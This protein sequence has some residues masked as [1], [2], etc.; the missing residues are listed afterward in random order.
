MGTE[1]QPVV[2]CVGDPFGVGANCLFPPSHF[3][4][5]ALPY[6]DHL[7]PMIVAVPCCDTH[8]ALVCDFVTSSSSMEA[9]LCPMSELQHVQER[10][11]ALGEDLSLYVRSEA[12]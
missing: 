2:R 1:G 4:F 7:S 3:V 8:Q 11:A 5:G 9:H 12:A 10:M 6:G